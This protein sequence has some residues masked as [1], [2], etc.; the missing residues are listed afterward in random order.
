MKKTSFVKD[1]A[2][3]IAGI[4]ICK[5]I[6]LLYVIPFYAMISTSGGALYSYA[7]SIYALFLSLS[8]S[9]IPTAISKIISEYDALNYNKTKIQV[10]KLGLK[11]ITILG[12]AAFI[13]MIVFA[14][15]LA[16]LLIGNMQGGNS[17]SDV[18]LVIRIISTALLIVPLLSV[19][20][21]YFQGLK[22][23]KEASIANILEQIARVGFLLLGCYLILNNFKLEEKFAI[24]A[25]VFSATIGAL[26]AYLYLL[27][28]IKKGKNNFTNIEINKEEKISSNKKIIKQIISVAIPFVL[29]DLL[30]TAYSMVDSFTVIRGLTY[31]GYS[32]E[33]AE[34]AFST[35]ATWANKLF[36]IIVSIAVGL[37]ISLIPNLAADN[38]TQ[39]KEKVD[40]KINLS[41]L[42]ILFITLPMC[43][44]ISFLAKPVWLL[45]YSY[46]E[47]SIEILR[48]IIFIAGTFS[49]Y[50]VVINITQTLNHTKQVLKALIF[51]FLLNLIGNIPCMCLCH[52]LG[53]HAYHG[54]SIWTLITEIIPTLYL[55]HYIKKEHNISFKETFKNLLKVIFSNIIMII[56]LYLLSLI[57][58][59]ESMTRFGS[60]LEVVIYTLVG[61]ISYFIVAFKTGLIKTIF[62]N[63]LNKFINK[64]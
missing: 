1:S 14:K 28:K 52:F 63:R 17:I 16:Y 43:I 7:Y 6:G 54:V 9:G 21:G 38:I 59:L 64:K 27:I 18:T 60:L 62:G 3:S 56:V 61:F 19:T 37:S 12:I 13:L 47:I 29:I 23:F 11:L 15:P 32:A 53:I 40:H 33:V 31:L 41:I 2:I 39:D 20:K 24:C 45:F 58:P 22:K 48:L 42:A 5:V 55:L 57:Y 44:G 50:T 25:A 49:L 51:A 35:I 10:Y 34:L 30:K 8:T 4:V 26:V 36:M 46:N